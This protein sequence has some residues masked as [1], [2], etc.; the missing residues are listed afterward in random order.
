MA[1]GE[2]ALLNNT[3]GNDNTATGSEAL[4]NNTTGS[5]NIALG[6]LAGSDTTGNNNID[7]GNPGVAAEANTIRIGNANHSNTYIA[8]ISGVTIAT[9]SPA[10]VIDNTGQLGTVDISALQ[11]PAGPTGP[12]GAQGIQGLT[13]ATS[14]TGAQGIQGL[15]GAT[16]PQGSPGPTGATGPQGNT[17]LT[18]ATGPTGPTGATGAGLQTGSLLFLISPSSTPDGFTRIGTTQQNIRNLTNQ[19]LTVTLDVYQKN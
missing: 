4:L 13:G 6:F 2:R 16:G 5:D 9:G 1:N 19:S 11:G 12:Q 15:T 7:I 17:G 3:T 10:V 18:G 8:G 14:N